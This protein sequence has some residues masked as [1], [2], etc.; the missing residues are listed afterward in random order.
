MISIMAG[1][2]R[3]AMR[4]ATSPT[5][6]VTVITWTRQH[7][8]DGRFASLERVTCNP[9]TTVPLVTAVVIDCHSQL[10]FDS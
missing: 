7:E 3:S 4:R 10:A 5:A 9:T 1:F 6:G 8:G 2:K